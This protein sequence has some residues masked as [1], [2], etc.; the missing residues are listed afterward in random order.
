MKK[1]LT[2][3]LIAVVIMGCTN[4]S[5]GTVPV[6]STTTAAELLPTINEYDTVPATEMISKVNL[7]M[8]AAQINN[9]LNPD[10]T[11]KI[12]NF[13]SCYVDKGIISGQGYIR[14]DYPLS[15][16]VA[17]IADKTKATDPKIFLRCAVNAAFGLPAM[18]IVGPGQRDIQ[19]CKQMY[20]FSGS[21]GRT[22]SVVY[23]ALTP[24]ACTEI[25]KKLPACSITS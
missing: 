20:E 8:S 11:T 1:I 21:D 25:C 12:T 23:V 13:A 15:A 7:A 9:P 4:V 6:N 17:F 14:K 19:P 10:I 24:E 3:L 16:G 5:R 18:S 22:F 2:V